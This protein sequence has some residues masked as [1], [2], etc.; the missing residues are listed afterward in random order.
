MTRHT[1]LSDIIGSEDHYGDMD[2]KLC[3]TTEGVTGF[4]LDLKLPGISHELM[5]AAIHDAKEKR[6]P[7]CST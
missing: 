6:M 2:F 4:Q 3:G 1:L 5:A 7:R